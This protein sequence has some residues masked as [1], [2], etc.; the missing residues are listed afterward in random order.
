MIVIV[1]KYA[2]PDHSGAG[3]RMYSFFQYLKEKGYEVRYLTNTS[4]VEN[5]VIVIKKYPLKQYPSGIASIITFLYSFFYLVYTFLNGRFTV[6]DGVRVVWLVSASPLTAAAGVFFNLL[7]Y[8]VI[9]QN[10]LMHSD[11][12]GRRPSGI[13]N[14]THKLR[15]I[16]YYLSDVVTSNSPRLYELSKKHHPNCVM[17]PN[18]VELQKINR[19]EKPRSG[20]NII[21]V[22]RL[23]HRKGTDI[24]FKTIDIIHRS[25]PDIQFTF[26]GPYDNMDERLQN[27][28][29][30]CENINRKNVHFAGYQEDTRP[31]Y[32]NADIFFLP[33]RKEG[34]PSVFIEAM[35]YGLPVVVKKLE[36]ITDF[37]FQ[38]GYPAVIDSEEPNEYAK[39]IIKL[40]GD[41]DY[42][43]SLI[44]GLQKNVARFDK[45]KIYERYLQLIANR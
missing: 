18:P 4:L 2:P 9:T 10:V 13:L 41:D 30:T 28:Y 39:V 7:G 1:S 17:I 11:D 35:A 19:W 21:I 36:G 38:N 44:K 43:V 26:V 29:D 22:G 24:V 14:I 25:D 6:T 12:P 5:N 42:F 27:V 31:W 34:F 40:I 23:S 33:S 8:S 37:I 45:D 15:M 16:Q 20:K 32:M 3:K